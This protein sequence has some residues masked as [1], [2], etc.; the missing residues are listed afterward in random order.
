MPKRSVEKWVHVACAALLLVVLLL[1]GAQVL[2]RSRFMAWKQV[3]SNLTFLALWISACLAFGVVL[4][5]RLLKPT[6]A[7]L[8]SWS[9]AFALGALAFSLAIAL[10][11]WAGWLNRLTLYAL[12]MGFI[13]VGALTVS[14]WWRTAAVVKPVAF[15]RAEVWFASVGFFFVAVLFV[16]ALAP[17]N[18]NYDAMWYHLRVAERYALAG[19]LVRFPEGDHLLTLPQ[20]GSWLYTWAFLRPGTL[21]DR[22]QLALLMEW[23]SVVGALALVPQL[24]R[25]VAPHLG[26]DDVRLS[27]VAFFLFPSIFVYDTGI[28]GGSDHLATLFTGPMVVLY[29]VARQQKNL[30]AWCLWGFSLVGVL[31]K[32][33]AAFFWVPLLTT[34]VLDA[35]YRQA[36]SDRRAW[37]QLTVAGL[38][39]LGSSAVQW[40]RH[41]SWYG[42][43]VYPLGARLFTNRPWNV[44]ATAWMGRSSMAVESLKPEAA[45]Q[46]L[47]KG[48]LLSQY[49]YAT[50]L[51]TWGDF[52]QGQPL[53]GIAFLLALPGLLFLKKSHR[54]W[55]TACWC[56]A[57]IAIWFVLSHQMRYLAVFVPLMAAFVAVVVIQLWRQGGASVR[58]VLGVA[59]AF[60]V[61]IFVD[62]PARRTHRMVGT[63]ALE[64]SL[65]YLN[66]GGVTQHGPF[67][68]FK[69]IDKMVK[70]EAVFL[71]HGIWPHLGLGHQSVGD[72][73]GFQFGINY[74]RLGS[75]AAIV[76]HLKSLGVDTVLWRDAS[77]RADSVAGEA[78]FAGLVSQLGSMQDVSGYHFA[79]LP[80]TTTELRPNLLLVGC[81]GLFDTGLY[82]L[83]ALKTPIPIPPQK[84]QW[85]NPERTSEDWHLLEP[86][87][88]VIVIQDG[89]PGRPESTGFQEKLL[90]VAYAANL[91]YFVRMPMPQKAP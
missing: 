91:H 18:V 90:Q 54:L 11:G 82:A 69:A 55:L 89:C 48:T 56:Q 81:G 45:Q 61:V 35:L 20:A 68:V 39:A 37:L 25:S 41:F 33:S 84:V 43:P 31:A 3:L 70:A 13:L 63:T 83:D 29:F 80:Q 8:R 40:L 65:D 87:V 66:R 67:E 27:W 49:Q 38:V 85:P 1:V 64:R 86:E 5:E 52:T 76:T 19:G 47:F 53:F 12:P 88:D 17:E 78:L 6:R 71:V 26:V 51:F 9:L 62:S 15:S 44:D 32:Y 36:R 77:E 60:Q 75:V 23:A 73:P 2:P 22:V 50:E 58:V 24:A 59:L 46:N 79:P 72:D 42:N 21:Q 30:G 10:L 7:S 57:G 34:A 4:I 28:M 14:M 16:S 74:G